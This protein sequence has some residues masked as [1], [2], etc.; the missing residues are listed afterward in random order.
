MDPGCTNVVVLVHSKGILFHAPN[1][2]SFLKQTYPQ[3]K[4]SYVLN[5]S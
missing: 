4:T 2:L 1:T 3:Y 5:G